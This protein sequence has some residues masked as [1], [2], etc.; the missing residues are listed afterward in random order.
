MT[1]V[2]FVVLVLLALAALAVGVLGLSH[3]HDHQSAT[4]APVA[5]PTPG[6]GVSDVI[7]AFDGG[8]LFGLRNESDEPFH[9]LGW[10]EVA[11][12]EV[13]T[14][15]FRGGAHPTGEGRVL[16]ERHS[17]DAGV[18]LWLPNGARHVAPTPECNPDVAAAAPQ[19][20]GTVVPC[21]PGLLRVLDG[22]ALVLDAEES[23]S[24]ENLVAWQGNA[25]FTAI[26]GDGVEAT[27]WLGTDV[28][29]P[30]KVVDTPVT[31]WRLEGGVAMVHDETE[32]MTIDLRTG[33]V[34]NAVRVGGDAPFA[35]GTTL[36]VVPIEERGLLGCEYR[37]WTPAL[38]SKR[39]VVAPCLDPSTGLT[40]VTPALTLFHLESGEAG[41][42][43]VHDDG[44]THGLSKERLEHV[45]CS[46]TTCLGVS[47]GGA[48]VAVDLKA[49]AEQ[50]M[51]PELEAFDAT[52]VHVT[53]STFVL[54]REHCAD[55]MLWTPGS[56]PR[57]VSLDGSAGCPVGAV[58]PVA[59]DVGP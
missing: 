52:G 54:H 20:D 50:P 41:S 14:W 1:K 15:A 7:Q 26:D 23:L 47:L 28:S 36:T 21:P 48:P 43:L 40:P 4:P 39:V 42:T 58:A 53:G 44:R 18:E 16:L 9:T 17:G 3:L 6:N 59:N 33:V 30:V 51:P 46:A 10:L 45:A 12:G 34:T 5:S 24:P 57:L 25:L 27:F 49:F 13:R 35:A 32:A 22:G 38:V 2:G 31:L 29:A 11:S 8:V 37:R 56:T 55:V 19:S